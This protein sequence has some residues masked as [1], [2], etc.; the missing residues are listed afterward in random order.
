M[1]CSNRFV[2]EVYNWIFW[3]K[4]F[5]LGTYIG[6]N[7]IYLL[8]VLGWLLGHGTS[9]M[10]WMSTSSTKWISF[11]FFSTNII[12]VTSVF[13]IITCGPNNH[14]VSLW[15]IL[16]ELT[17]LVMVHLLVVVSFLTIMGPSLHGFYYK[18]SSSSS[19]IVEIWTL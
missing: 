14:L 4:N 19:I 18:V 6:L 12:W 3:S 8:P 1:I 13:N 5:S 16:M 10:V 9:S 15:W 11:I 17:L 7:G 2:K